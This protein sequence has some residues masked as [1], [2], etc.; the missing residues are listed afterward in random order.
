M[1]D[2]EG[3]RGGGASTVGVRMRG[4][5]T[6]RCSAAFLVPFFLVCAS[7]F[8]FFVMHL[9]LN[10]RKHVGERWERDIGDR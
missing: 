7:C 4:L 10:Q 6:A 9:F 1:G 2:G 3:E 8:S 5:P